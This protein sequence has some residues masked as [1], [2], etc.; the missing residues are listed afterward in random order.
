MASA[1]SVHS[2]LS[3]SCVLT[4]GQVASLFRAPSKRRPLAILRSHFSPSRRKRCSSSSPL[5]EFSL[6]WYFPCLCSLEGSRNP[7]SPHLRVKDLNSSLTVCG[8]L[9]CKPPSAVLQKSLTDSLSQRF[10][11]PVR[12]AKNTTSF[13]LFPTQCNCPHSDPH[14]CL[15]L[16][17]N[18]NI[19]LFIIPSENPS[20]RCHIED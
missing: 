5:W 15:L 12:L 18:S 14:L 2:M 10:A 19:V 9:V 16:G 3:Y 13:S 8:N 4:D 7:V 20:G 11:F 6:F 17:S 1:L